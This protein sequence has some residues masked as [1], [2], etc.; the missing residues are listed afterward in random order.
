MKDRIIDPYN[1]AFNDP[2]PEA[3]LRFRIEPEWRAYN[4]RL[5]RLF[6]ARVM[7]VRK[8]ARRM[9]AATVQLTQSAAKASAAINRLSEAMKNVPPCN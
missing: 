1:P 8:A 5:L 2:W 6:D 7:E 9:K 3:D 4:K